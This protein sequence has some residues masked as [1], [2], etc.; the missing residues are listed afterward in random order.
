[1]TGPDFGGKQ[2]HFVQIGLGTNTTFIQNLAGQDQDWSGCI[3]QL[4]STCSERRPKFVRGIAVEPVKHHAA[5]MRS[6][7]AKHLQHVFVLQAA[8]G[9]EDDDSVDLH[10]LESPE[11]LIAKAPENLQKHLRQ[12]LVYLENMSCVGGAHPEFDGL[13]ALIKQMY[14]VQANMVLQTVKRLSWTSLVRKFKFSGCQVLLLDTEGYDVRI[15]RSMLKHCQ[16]FP[17]ELP[18]LIQFETRGH[19]DYFEGANSE[20][21]IIVSLEAVGYKLVAKSES[22][23]LVVHGTAL[24]GSIKLDDWC[25]SWVCDTCHK[26]DDMPYYWQGS[27]CWCKQCCEWWFYRSPIEPDWQ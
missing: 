4:L 21:N 27:R 6:L 17:T 5:A 3:H 11:E 7:A 19:C 13:Q 15:L 20:E 26:Q 23:T 24:E 9:E 16:A 10:V 2:A 22:D 25:Q 18:E 1:M 12:E 14:G 8:I